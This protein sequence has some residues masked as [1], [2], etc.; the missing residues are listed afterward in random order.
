[1][2]K[3]LLLL[4]L[5]FACK[6]VMSQTAATNTGILYVTGSSDILFAGS[7]FT[8]NSGSAL[9][10]NGQLYI[11]GNLTNNQ[12]AM[13]IGTGTLYLNGSSAQSVNGSQSFKTYHLNTNNGAGITL[14]NNL[15]VSGIHTFASGIITTSATPNYLVYEA[16]SSYTGDADSRHVNGWV[17]KFGTTNFAFPVGTATIERT[18]G[19]TNLSVSSEIN[20]IYRQPTTN[21][22]NLQGPLVQVQDKEYWQIDKISGGTAQIALNWDNSKVTFPPVLVTDIRVAYYTG[23][24]WTNQGGSATGSYLTTGS[25]TSNVVGSFGPFTFGFVSIPLALDLINFTAE[26]KA[27]YTRLNWTTAHEQGVDHFTIERSDDAV[28]FYGI[29]KVTARNTGN[30]E[31]Y[32]SNDYAPIR[33][34]A[35]YRL[36]SVDINGKE[37]LSAI[38]SVK[39]ENSGN[40]LTLVINPVH[41]QVIL[42]ASSELNGVFDYRLHAIDGKLMQEGNLTIQNGGQYTLSLKG[43]F[44]PGTYTLEVSN[45]IENFRYKLVVR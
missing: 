23:S 44:E 15:S 33:N 41:D 9:T 11:K 7:D 13:A 27:N 21:I 22:Y 28:Q 36:R 5:L 37:K 1:M 43:N 8:N 25:V 2:K 3:N 45:K 6:L 32:S 14:N 30:A 35:Y 29:T 24:L 34:I 26:R 38:V 12:S 4:S 39:A 19:I 17:K 20:A 18:A 16:G 10:N 40:L 42:A 31:S